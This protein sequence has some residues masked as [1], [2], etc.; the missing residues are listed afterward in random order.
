MTKKEIKQVEEAMRLFRTDDGFLPAMRILRVLT[1]GP[2]ETHYEKSL[3]EAHLVEVR[4]L[5]RKH[6]ED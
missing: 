5:F 3:R 6:Q 2:E 4:T 1:G